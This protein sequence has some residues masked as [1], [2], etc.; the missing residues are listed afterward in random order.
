MNRSAV[1]QTLEALNI[2]PDEIADERLAEVFRVLLLLI[3]ELYEENEKLKEE[4]QKLRDAINL[5]PD[6][7]QGSVLRWWLSFPQV[8]FAP[9]GYYEFCSAHSLSFLLIHHLIF[10]IRRTRLAS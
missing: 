1:T 4:N 6:R 2:R 7:M 8:G 9:T 10:R 3:E 5:L